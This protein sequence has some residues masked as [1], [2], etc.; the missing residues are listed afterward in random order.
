DLLERDAIV[1]SPECGAQRGVEPRARHP[2]DEGEWREERARAS[3]LCTAHQRF[4]RAAEHLRVDGCFAPRCAL[5]SRGEPVLAE[6]VEQET[7]VC[8]IGEF[9]A[10]RR[11]LERRATEQAA[12]EKRHA[13]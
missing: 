5:L 9:H 11:T 2:L 13:S 1:R 12:V 8:I 4:E 6:Q 3:S 10:V 7:T